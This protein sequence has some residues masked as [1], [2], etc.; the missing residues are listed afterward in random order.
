M[1]LLQVRDPSGFYSLRSASPP[2]DFGEMNVQL[3]VGPLVFESMF[4]SDWLVIAN[5]GPPPC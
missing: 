4:D 2:Y 3:S 1:I 5:D